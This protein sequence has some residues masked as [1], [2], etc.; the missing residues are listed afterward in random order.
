MTHTK[1]IPG[2][3]LDLTDRTGFIITCAAR[4]ASRANANVLLAGLE[5]VFVN[6]PEEPQDDLTGIDSL[7]V[8]VDTDHVRID[9]LIAQNEAV[10]D[11]A[12]QLLPAVK[13]RL[14]ARLQ[15]VP[16]LGGS[17]VTFHSAAAVYLGEVITQTLLLRCVGQDR[18]D[19]SAPETLAIPVTAA[20]KGLLRT[21]RTEIASGRRTFNADGMEFCPYLT[22]PGASSVMRGLAPALTEAEKE[23]LGTGLA[24]LTL[25]FIDDGLYGHGEI[26]DD[27][28]VTY[29]SFVIRDMPWAVLEA[30]GL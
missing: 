1:P 16:D 5:D 12:G 25:Q 20:L 10:L 23:A 30:A 27:V 21:A 17:P 24:M 8:S 19:E 7:S 13:A 9:L 29:G 11:H 6:H 14:T 28:H 15:D 2:T 3:P 22:R 18:R 4:S 26:S